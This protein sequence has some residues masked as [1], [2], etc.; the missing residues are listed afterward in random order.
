MRQASLIDPTISNSQRNWEIVRGGES[1]FRFFSLY[2]P[3]EQLDAF[4]QIF[5]LQVAKTFTP[6]VLFANYVALD[7]PLTRLV[8]HQMAQ[9]GL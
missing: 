3:L 7:L 9:G 1:S 6:L 5:L 4:E 2:H 8:T